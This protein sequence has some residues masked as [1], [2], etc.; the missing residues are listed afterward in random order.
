M[1]LYADAVDACLCF[2]TLDMSDSKGA[3]E[4]GVI[5]LS[6]GPGKAI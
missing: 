1:A 4:E 2:L 5:S 6:P 3:A